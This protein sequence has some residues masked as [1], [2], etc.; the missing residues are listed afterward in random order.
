[1][2]REKVLITGGSGYLGSVITGHLLEK[3]YAVTCLDNLSLNQKSLLIYTSNSNFNFIYGDSRDGELLKKIIPDFD[4]IIPLAAIVGMPAC[5]EHPL[6]AK[7]IN[8]DS[9]VLINE[10]RSPNQKIIFPN[11][12]SGYGIGTKEQYCTEET[13]LN[14]ISLYGKT[15]CDAE[16]YLL[17]HEKDAVTLRLA[18]VFGISPRMRTDLMVND[19]VLR[20]VREG[21]IILFE[22]DFKR[23][24][25]HV[26]DVARCFE[27]CIQNYD[28]MKN[29]PYNLGLDEANISKL[30]LAKLIKKHISNFEIIE[31]EIGEDP[32]KRDY[33]VSNKR[34]EEVGF[35]AEISLNEGIKELIKAYSILIKN[36]PYQNV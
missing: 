27:Y 10:I 5:K 33:I 22:K 26:R 30:E 19:F 35:K 3:G 36:D 1:M 32:D 34:L 25:V 28:S 31:K 20:A 6:D 11:T 23:N 8:Y 15:K 29:K 4:V 18:T 17:D 14:P 7:T 12:N 24:F 21:V 16:K 13:P 9:I 2:T